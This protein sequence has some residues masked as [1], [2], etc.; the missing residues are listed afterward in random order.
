MQHEGSSADSCLSAYVQVSVSHTKYLSKM[1]GPGN[2]VYQLSLSALP[3]LGKTD[4]SQ[5]CY[6]KVLKLTIV[7][8]FTQT[9]V[10]H[11][12]VR[13]TQNASRGCTLSLKKRDTLR[14]KDVKKAQKLV[15]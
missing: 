15:T 3:R 14:L 7:T 2:L 11:E 13:A 9:P 4:H 1:K 6:P 12:L 5:M 8:E 10:Y